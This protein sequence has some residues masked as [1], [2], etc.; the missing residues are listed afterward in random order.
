M[1]R[2]NHKQLLEYA[3]LNTLV[4]ATTDV[5][6]KNFFLY[7]EALAALATAWIADAA[8]ASRQS[9]FHPSSPASVSTRIANL[10]A[11]L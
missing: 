10:S 3:E 9:L 4:M 7:R 5:D 1:N 8:F 2:R 6:R 11:G